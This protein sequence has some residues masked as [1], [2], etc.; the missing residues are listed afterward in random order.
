MREQ[1]AALHAAA[2]SGR[3]DIVQARRCARAPRSAPSFQLQILL[4]AG[5]DA[6]ALDM[7]KASPLHRAAASGSTHTVTPRSSP[8]R[9]LQVASP[10][11]HPYLRYPFYS[12]PARVWTLSTSLAPL[13][14]AGL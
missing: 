5:H 3:E 8:R 14:T 13:L 4:Q 1:W 12:K 2:D 10:P 7:H 9:C 6:N 11:C